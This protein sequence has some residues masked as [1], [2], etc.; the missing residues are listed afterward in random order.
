MVMD[1]GRY[2]ISP[3]LVSERY[4]EPYRRDPGADIR[5]GIGRQ[6]KHVLC[7]VVRAWTLT[8]AARAAD[9]PP[10]WRVGILDPTRAIV[11]RASAIGPLDPLI[12]K[13]STRPVP[14]RPM[15]PD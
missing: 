2:N 1:T 8:N 7:V 3:V 4:K 12:G 5:S 10:H 11:G 15:P 6:C 13:V 9:P 14:S